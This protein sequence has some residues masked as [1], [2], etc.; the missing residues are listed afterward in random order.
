MYSRPV[1]EYDY[2]DL[3]TLREFLECVMAGAFIDYDGN[4]H[5]VR[6]DLVDTSVTVLPSKANDIP[7]DATHIIWFNK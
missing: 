6:G 7:S 3:M 2:G 5:P 4:G 1:T